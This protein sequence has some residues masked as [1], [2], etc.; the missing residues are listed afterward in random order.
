MK[1]VDPELKKIITNFL[2]EEQTDV[3]RIFHGRGQRYPG[4]EHVCV[5]WFSPSVLITLF[6]DYDQLEELASH[7]NAVDIHQQVGSIVVQKRFE[8]GVPA[9]ALKGAISEELIVSEGALRFEVHFGKHQNIGLFLDMR[10]L[11]DWLQKHS[12]DKNVLNL[13]AYTCS[14]SVAALAGGA[15]SVTNVDMSKPSIL[16][17]EK[18]HRLNNQESD[19]VKSIPHNIYKSWGRTHQFGRYD[20][21]IID[22]PTRQKG[23]FDVTKNYPSVIKRMSKLCN[24]GAEIIATVNS[25]F[26]DENFLLDLFAKHLPQSQF[27]STMEVAPEFEDAFPE[28]GLKIYR[29][30]YMA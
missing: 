21:V 2:S 25:P 11:R 17:G 1:P 6:N 27:V 16:W 23:S 14:L 18:N 20:L 8:K 24:P 5:D 30:S 22:P 28:R 10:L 12:K 13:F 15:S 4:L 7:I 29:F 9:I 3:R 26:L 19:R